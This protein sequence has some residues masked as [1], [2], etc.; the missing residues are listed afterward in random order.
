MTLSE[1][2]PGQKM[3]VVG[4]KMEFLE[5]TP[6][7]HPTFTAVLDGV[8]VNYTNKNWNKSTPIAKLNFVY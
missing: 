1:L 8:N 3:I 2:K 5:W 7:G 6:E 4:I